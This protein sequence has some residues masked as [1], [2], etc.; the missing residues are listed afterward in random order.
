MSEEIE[1]C[2]FNGIELKIGRLE[3]IWL[4]QKQIAQLFDT[5]KQNVGQHIK[6]FLQELDEEQIKV[7]VKKSFTTTQHGAIEGKAQTT[8]VMLYGFEVICQVGYRVN[9][10]RGFQFRQFATNAVMEKI[11]RDILN[12]DEEGNG[13]RIENERLKSRLGEAVMEI[14]ELEQDIRYLS[15]YA[16]PE[17]DY[18]K[19]AKNGYPRT[20][21]Q[22]GGFRSRG[23]RKVELR[24]QYVTI[25]LFAM[26]KYLMP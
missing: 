8:E 12:R 21:Y 10:K 1:R 23:G 4:T 14:S 22:K 26:Q 20:T 16:P 3:D 5:T 13:L 15:Q 17:S 18:G 6:N 24:P 11:N 2:M 19:I 9:G 7:V 25:D